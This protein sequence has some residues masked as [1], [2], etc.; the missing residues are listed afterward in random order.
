MSS[1][2]PSGIGKA[3]WPF[4]ADALPK[5]G[6]Q[7][8]RSVSRALLRLLGWRIAGEIPNSPKMILIGAPHTSNWDFLLT[9]ATMFALG[10]RF[11]WVAKD[12]L[13]R[14]PIARIMVW[15]GGVRLD[16]ATSEGFVDQMSDEFNKREHFL[17]ALMPEGTRSTSKAWRTGFYYIALRA[18]VP[19]LCVIFDYGRKR[20]G[21]EPA[22]EV[23]GELSADLKQIQSV[24]AGAKGKRSV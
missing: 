1:D 24:Y 11:S 3:D 5:R 4:V 16:R 20:L 7:F 12:V 2:E 18:K 8:T 13:F 14:W 23:S 9:I 6:N 21:L 19:I 22:L 10:V 15:L 17:L